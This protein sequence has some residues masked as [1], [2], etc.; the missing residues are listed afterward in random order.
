MSTND[1]ACMLNVFLSNEGEQG[2]GCGGTNY[3]ST[4]EQTVSINL[5]KKTANINLK[6]LSYLSDFPEPYFFLKISPKKCD[7]PKKKPKVVF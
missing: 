1:H 7:L 5:S 4:D 3:A 6:K 2:T